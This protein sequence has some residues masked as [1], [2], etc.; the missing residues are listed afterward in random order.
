VPGPGRP[1]LIT[2]L[3]LAAIGAGADFGAR[4]LAE[5]RLA[6]SIQ[7]SLGLQQRPDIELEGFPF[8]L[9]AARGRLEAAS[10]ELHDVVAEGMALERVTLSF[11]DL[12]FDGVALVSGSGTVAS[13]GGT[14]QVVLTEDALSGYLQDQGTPVEVRLRG[15]DIRVATR[16][17]TG[18]GTT[19]ATA[20]GPVRV[21][22]GRLVFSPED[23]QIEGSVGVPAAALAFDVPLPDLVPGIVYQRVL[24]QDGVAAI[25]ASLAGAELDLS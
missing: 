1:I 25:E 9:Q 12:V 20:E 19:T 4:A 8:L 10:V 16:I 11:E 17:A 2:L 22:S 21:E 6:S 24:I 14:A 5:A 18:A 23:V 3:V 15:P 7:G 13:R